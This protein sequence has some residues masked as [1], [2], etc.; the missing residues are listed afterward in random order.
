MI[1]ALVSVAVLFSLSC[2]AAPKGLCYVVTYRVSD[3]S[4][5]VYRPHWH[6]AP[7][8]VLALTQDGKI[9]LTFPD[10]QRFEFKR[11]DVGVVEEKCR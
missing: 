5:G 7:G 1:K 9:Q 2:A 10:G 8:D 11:E 4:H 6:T 3:P